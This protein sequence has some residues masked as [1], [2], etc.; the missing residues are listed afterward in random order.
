MWALPQLVSEQNLSMIVALN[1]F[2]LKP[3]IRIGEIASR[4][5]PARTVLEH[6]A[7]RKRAPLTRIAVMFAL[8]SSNGDPF[9]APNMKNSK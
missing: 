6:T 2:K 3:I 8:A 4:R 9:A 1:C 5:E 7:V